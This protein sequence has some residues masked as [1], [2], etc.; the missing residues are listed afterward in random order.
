MAELSEARADADVRLAAD[1]IEHR[2][3]LEVPADIDKKHRLAGHSQKTADVRTV[4]L[5]VSVDQGRPNK[6][7]S[8][9][10]IIEVLPVD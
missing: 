6:P 5:H 9:D 3:G 7:P 10:D 2:P 8:R 1:A 4:Y